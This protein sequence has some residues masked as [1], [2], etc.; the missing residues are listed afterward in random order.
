MVI[1]RRSGALDL[2]P[3]CQLHSR[4]D[5]SCR[6]GKQDISG[7]HSNGERNVSLKTGDRINIAVSLNPVNQPQAKPVD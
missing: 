2:F 5:W 1:E 3:Q 6:T 4:P 7:D